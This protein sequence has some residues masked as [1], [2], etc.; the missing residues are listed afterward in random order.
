MKFDLIAVDLDATLLSSHG[1]VT[2][3]TRDAL[4]RAHS[5][6]VEI[7]ICTGR[8]F[9]SAM[10]V[11]GGVS[12]ADEIVV[13]NGVV[14]KEA[15]T[16][17]TVF[18]S[19]F[20]P[21]NYAACIRAIR[22]ICPELPALVMV[23]EYPNYEFCADVVRD[24]NEYHM[25]YLRLSPAMLRAVESLESL[26]TE[27]IIQCCIQNKSERL[28]EVEGPLARATAGIAH[29][30][31]IRNTKYMGSS[32]E[33]LPQGASK[34]R[35]LQFLAGSYSIPPE[36]IMAIGDDLNDLAMIR[37]AGFGVAMANAVEPV[38]EAADWVT[39]DKDHDGVADA[40]E[41]YAF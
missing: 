4:E 24:A 18:S 10:E 34:W 31:M 13:N 8:R 29:V 40:I 16:G 6:G 27:R 19:F 41:R 22:R 37:G 21:D 33:V 25:E 17:R 15:A 39:A 38:R 7:V 28:V 1:I 26:P 5:A 32:L 3:R 12:F 35:A 20:T 30:F 14:A 23:D 9:S 2:P 36:R 11:L